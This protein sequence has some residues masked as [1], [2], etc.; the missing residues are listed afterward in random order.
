MAARRGSG[1]G[2]CRRLLTQLCPA[3]ASARASHHAEGRDAA[4]V[5]IVIGTDEAIAEPLN[6]K[7][8]REL[9]SSSGLPVTVSAAS[10]SVA[11]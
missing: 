11:G 5:P 7:D 6:S 10:G 4:A 9:C 1:T 2:V 3:P 8:R